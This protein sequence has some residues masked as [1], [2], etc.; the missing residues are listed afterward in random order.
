MEN[1]R[2]KIEIW[3]NKQKTKI[4]NDKLENKIGK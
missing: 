1:D 2:L 3:K 4:A